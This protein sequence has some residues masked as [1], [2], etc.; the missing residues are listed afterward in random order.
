MFKY[1]KREKLNK[2]KF[3]HTAVYC[4][5]YSDQWHLHYTCKG[6][7]LYLQKIKDCF[8]TITAFR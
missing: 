2:I 1:T 4:I 8:G 3:V 6:R 5:K 7:F